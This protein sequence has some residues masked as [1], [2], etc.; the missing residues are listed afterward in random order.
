MNTILKTLTL[1]ALLANSSSVLAGD[2]FIGVTGGQSN[3]SELNEACDELIDDNRLIGGFPV[4]CRVTEDSDTVLGVNAGYNFNSFIGVEAGYLD[5]GEYEADFSVA[6]LSV[7]ATA[8]LDLAYAGLVLS[9]FLSEAFSVSARVGGV[10]ANVEVTSLGFN[11]ELED[12]TTAFVG[13]SLDYR[14]TDHLSLQIRYD[15]LDVVD[16]TSAGIRYHF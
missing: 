1:G 4:S 7:P 6:G 14:F 5:L 10:N 12:E 11:L 3:F 16:I 8:T 2:F 13:A 9:A 15:D